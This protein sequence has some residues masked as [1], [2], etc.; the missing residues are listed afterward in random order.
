MI[1][2]LTLIIILLIIVQTGFS[3]V[4]TVKQDG[5]G[6]YTTIQDA[7]DA[8]VSGSTIIVYTGIYYE[9][10]D[11][12][13]KS[14]ITLASLYYYTPH[15]SLI[16]QTVIDGNQSGSCILVNKHEQDIEING[17]TIQNG[18]GHWNADRTGGG[19]YFL[20]AQALVKNC[21]IKNNTAHHGGGAE[22]MQL[23]QTFT[24][25]TQIL[26]TI[27]VSLQEAVSSVLKPHYYSI[28]LIDVI[29]I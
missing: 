22:Y 29:C 20:Y 14:N 25:Q 12:D 5:T 19:I 8:A 4:I 6:D 16:Q 7:L 24:S 1:R 15:D 10:I 2:P 26:L 13:G 27:M 28:V 11:F 23:N 17:F 18:I 3:Q 9:N 21:I